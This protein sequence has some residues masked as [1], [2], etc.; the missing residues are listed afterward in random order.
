M[1]RKLT[2]YES[3]QFKQALLAKQSDQY[4]EAERAGYSRGHFNYIINRKRPAPSSF[5]DF[6]HETIITNLAA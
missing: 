5:I 1:T 2:K 3:I 4:I 6:I